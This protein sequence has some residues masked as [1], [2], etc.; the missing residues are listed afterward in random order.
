MLKKEAM[1]WM[2]P[3]RMEATPFTMAIRQLPMA[4]NMPWICLREPLVTGRG[5]LMLD[6][7]VGRDPA[8]LRYEYAFARRN[9]AGYRAGG[10][11]PGQER[12]A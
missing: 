7:R 3:V 11:F 4:R 5:G 6:G 2:M 12:R 10:E 8:S 9:E 1:A